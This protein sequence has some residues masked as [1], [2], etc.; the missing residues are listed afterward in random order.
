MASAGVC[1]CLMA[2]DG[3]WV[4]L[5][6]RLHQEGNS[7]VLMSASPNDV[8]LGVRL[9]CWQALHA[10]EKITA[11]GLIAVSLGEVKHKDLR[12]HLMAF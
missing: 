6:A 5:T 1:W 8:C 4:L 7:D 10:F 3:V 12:A 9:V 11:R 2:C